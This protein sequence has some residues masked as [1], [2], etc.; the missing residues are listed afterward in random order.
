MSCRGSACAGSRPC[1]ALAGRRPGSA[2]PFGARPLRVRAACR[3]IVMG[4]GRM[5]DIR[6]IKARPCLARWDAA[7]YL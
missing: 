5:A 2:R 3:Q 4:N 1:S 6:Q 7:E